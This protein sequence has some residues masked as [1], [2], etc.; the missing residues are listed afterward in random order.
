MSY[1]KAQKRLSECSAEWL[2]KSR[3]FNP[4]QPFFDEPAAVKIVASSVNPSKSKLLRFHL[5]DVDG[6]HQAMLLI[7]PTAEIPPPGYQ[8][9]ENPEDNKRRWKKKQ[10]GKS[11]VLHD[12]RSLDAQKAATVEFNLPEQRKN[13]LEV[14]II[15]VHGNITYRTFDLKK[16]K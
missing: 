4:D 13:R 12:Y 3:Y 9:D 8:R 11:F 6:L 1:G 7:P 16:I 15:D 2:D 5:K 10:R 14:R